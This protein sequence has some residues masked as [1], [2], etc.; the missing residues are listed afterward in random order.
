MKL[1]IVLSCIAFVSALSFAH[2]GPHGPDI[3]DGGNYGGQLAAVIKLGDKHDHEGEKGGKH[4]EHEP[5]IEYKAEFV[6]KEGQEVQLFFYQKDNINKNADISSFPAKLDGSVESEWKGKKEQQAFTFEKKGDLYVG[7]AP[8]PKRKPF[9]LEV[10]FKM[11]GETY[12][13]GI[14]NQD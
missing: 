10:Q 11:K 12:F 6:R 9:N 13:A 4:K 3:N 14:K 7:K 2:D 5:E 1:K 8:T